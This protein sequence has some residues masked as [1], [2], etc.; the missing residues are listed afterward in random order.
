MSAGT[1]PTSSRIQISPPTRDWWGTVNVPTEMR[2]RRSWA[3]ASY[4][5]ARK[6][7]S[8]VTQSPYRTW[9]DPM[10][11]SCYTLTL[12]SRIML[13]TTYPIIGC[14]RHLDS[15][16]VD[17]CHHAFFSA[18]PAS[19]WLFPTVP[20]GLHQAGDLPARLEWKQRSNKDDWHVLWAGMELHSQ[21]GPVRKSSGKTILCFVPNCINMIDSYS[22]ITST[23]ACPSM[24]Q[25][26]ATRRKNS[27][28]DSQGS[29]GSIH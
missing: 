25:D 17:I 23:G 21:Q 5:F 2:T 10:S 4:S 9:A 15:F 1:S 27:G 26:L 20:V 24:R 22:R 12:L 16:H 28:S 13:V 3:T 8:G 19:E 7:P 18:K 11:W 6:A 29:E 14:R